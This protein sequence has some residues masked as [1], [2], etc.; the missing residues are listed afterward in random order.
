MWMANNVLIVGQIPDPHIEKVASLL[1]EFGA[2]PII[3][4]CFQKDHLLE[5]SVNANGP[6]GAVNIGGVSWSFET[7][8]A[9]WWRWKPFS[10]AEWTG[11]FAKVAEDFATQ[12]W[13]T[14]L[15]SLPAFLPHVRWVN[16]LTEHFRATRKPWQLALAHAVGFRLA[17]TVFTNN[18]QRVLAQ[19]SQHSRLVYKTISSFIVPPDEIIFTNEVSEADV[20]N[21]VD[22]IRLAP[23]I[24]QQ[25]I[26]K[27]YELRVTIV[28]QEIFAARINSQKSGETSLDWRRNQFESMYEVADLDEDLSKRL[29]A[30]HAGAGLLFGAY[31]LIVPTEG[32]PIFLECNPGGQWLW[33]EM[34]LGLWV[35]EALAKLLVRL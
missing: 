8:Q 9:V 28:D 20:R 10:A 12:E 25:L 6:T 22:N 1:R 11:A 23:G 2:T 13:R 21:S 30:F 3:F 4:D 17:D 5:L 14:T 27:D 33:L 19:F 26:E 29:L 18:S 15:L 16:P 7:I 35:S 34:R 31:D 24:F 32:S